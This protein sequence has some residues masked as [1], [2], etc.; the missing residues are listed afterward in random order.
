LST[1]TGGSLVRAPAGAEHAPMSREPA[2]WDPVSGW[3]DDPAEAAPRWLPAPDVPGRRPA[4]QPRRAARLGLVVAVA[5]AVAVALVWP[6][7]AR[8]RADRP[9]A[10]G[11]PAAAGAAMAPAPYAFTRPSGWQDATREHGPRFPGARPEVVLVSAAGAGPAANL[12]VVRTRA[13]AGRTPLGSLPTAALRRLQV[14]G[15]RLV[16][17]P[18]RF[19]LA[20]ELAV[21]ADY[22][23]PRRRGRLRARQVACYHRGHLYLVTLTAEASAFPSKT[24]AQDRLLRSWRWA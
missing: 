3:D 10:T 18:R 6:G 24:V 2:G 14:A 21:A 16:G 8:D 4:A 1:G 7:V 20:G 19:A 9:A 11:G 23:L 13:G 5:A 17:R 15:A 12:S 22:E